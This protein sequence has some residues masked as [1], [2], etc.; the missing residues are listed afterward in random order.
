MKLLIIGLGSQSDIVQQVAEDIYSD[1]EIFFTS[2]NSH[3]FDKKISTD[4]N[5][6]GDILSVKNI[7]NYNCITAIGD[8]YLRKEIVNQINEKF[9]TI[10]WIS[11]IH[12]S[13][14]IPKNINIG[15]GTIIS[16]NV[17]IQTK[18]TIG[19]HCVINSNSSIDH[20][21][22]ID[23]YVHIAPGST[24]CGNVKILQGTFLGANSTIIPKIKIKPWC[25]NKANT[26]CKKSN[27]PIPNYEPNIQKYRTSIIDCI[28]SNWLTFR[29]KY[30]GMVCDKIKKKFGY[31]YSILVSNGTVATH[32]LFLATKYFYPKSKTV[33]VPNNVYIAAWNSVLME[34]D[35]DD[36][37][38]MS[39]D[40]N[41]LNI[42]TSEE[43]ILKLEK[44]AIVLIVHNSSSIVNVKKLKRLRPDLIFVEDNCEGFF[45]KYENEYSGNGSLCGSMSFFANKNL[46][47]GEGG[48]IVTNNKEVYDFLNCKIHGGITDKRFLHCMHGFNYRITNLQA[49]LLNDQLDDIES[50][51]NRKKE[52]FENYDKLFK[53]LKKIKII[54]TEKNT[55]KSYWMYCLKFDELNF[56][57]FE[58]FM[59][60]KEVEVRPFFYPID[61][62]EHLKTI[63]YEEKYESQN[64]HN[65]VVFFPS[66][67]NI[68]YKEQEYIRDCVNEYLKKQS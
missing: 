38:V 47:S 51:Y 17:S 48:C 12:P 41:T 57:N 13:S 54:E 27:C 40:S 58:N 19:N 7:E 10:K 67:P 59:K 64:L 14:Y 53:N 2:Y 37:K 3:K 20:H 23:D 68:T 66:Y 65:S 50:I 52:I 55:E 26:L 29:G 28:D 1:S 63:K 9:K 18:T 15:I 33:Y 39:M 22:F 16:P 4:I 60:E 5:Y 44:N 21:C 24:V 36:I 6:L 32:C 8:N 34:Y 25:I 11:L 56:E 46:T 42:D 35:I 62:H 49:G 31:K 30:V 61:F 43:K 45:G